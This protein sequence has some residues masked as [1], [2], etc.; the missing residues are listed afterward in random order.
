M[1][2]EGGSG[3]EEAGDAGV[4]GG[5]GVEEAGDA[6]VDGGSGGD[7]AGLGSAQA[8]VS[9]SVKRQRD[10]RDTI[11]ALSSIIGERVLSSVIAVSLV[12]GGG[13]HPHLNPLPSKGEEAPLLPRRRL[14]VTAGTVWNHGKGIT[15]GMK[16]AALRR[17]SESK[18]R[19]LDTL[20]SQTK[21]NT[22]LGCCHGKAL[23]TCHH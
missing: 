19:G 18:G 6:G 14:C 2:A 7:G 13:N 10:R 8:A 21:C 20:D 15:M 9:R 5:I 16:M 4:D 12:E 3:V 22:L 23:W 17:R 1:G 11:A